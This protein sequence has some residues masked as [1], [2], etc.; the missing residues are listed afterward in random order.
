MSWRDK[1][2]YSVDK[3]GDLYGVD[4][5]G[6]NSSAVWNFNLTSG[7][8]MDIVIDAESNFITVTNQNG[9]ISK[10]EQTATGVTKKW[11]Y[12][13]T[14]A[15]NGC[16]KIGADKYNRYYAASTSSNTFIRFSEDKDGNP[17]RD[18][19]YTWSG[20]TGAWAFAID[21]KGYV[22]LGTAGNEIRL[23]DP[24]GNHVWTFTGANDTIRDVN[25]DAEG[26]IY[27]LQ[28]YNQRFFK[29]NRE[30]TEVWRYTDLESRMFGTSI[31]KDKDIYLVG[32]EGNLLYIKEDG[33]GTPQEQWKID[34]SPG[35]TGFDGLTHQVA[36]KPDNSKFFVCGYGSIE[37]I[38]KL[39][40]DEQGNPEIVWE[41][42]RMQD[43]VREVRTH[44]EFQGTWPAHFGLVGFGTNKAINGIK[45]TL[46]GVVRGY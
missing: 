22:A 29:I 1:R 42:D 6:N 5:E 17:V 12:N 37:S 24:E 34:L 30:G 14:E 16:R 2:V 8:A 15:S 33:E 35:Q 21:E 11:D 7:Q 38:F 44:Y 4:D 27:A 45:R 25:F 40:E 28:E 18:W 10:Y 26:N 36:A 13:F 19:T 20:G 32:W 46:G 41:D 39:V 3:N 31:T 43:E 9:N 23:I